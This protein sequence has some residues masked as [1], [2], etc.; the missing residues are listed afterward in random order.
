MVV[1]DTSIWIEASRRDGNAE[2][3]LGLEGLLEEYE[4]AVCRPVL[5]EFL[6]GAR[7]REREWLQDQMACL[8][9]LGVTDHHWD[10]ACR[11]A[12]ILRDAGETI[13]WNDILIASVALD[14]DLRVY[15]RDSH[16]GIM[17]GVLGLRPYQPGYCGRFVPD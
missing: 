3:K 6:G 15:A 8:P 5:L 7:K 14:R 12:W 10:A 1:V 16:F 2:C 9:R 4:A 11:H 13:P 17:A